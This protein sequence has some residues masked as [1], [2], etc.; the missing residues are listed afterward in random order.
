MPPYMSIKLPELIYSQPVYL[1]NQDKLMEPNSILDATQ[2]QLHNSKD[3]LLLKW[4]EMDVPLWCNGTYITPHE[5]KRA[6]ITLAL[7][8]KNTSRSLSGLGDTKR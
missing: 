4:K 1:N 7:A 5:V 8:L 3:H 2:E 6:A